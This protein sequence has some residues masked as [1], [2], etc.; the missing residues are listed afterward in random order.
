MEKNQMSK[1][2]PPG[3]LAR[4]RDG[5]WFVCD[6]P[7]HCLAG[8]FATYGGALGWILQNETKDAVKRNYMHCRAG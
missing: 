3:W 2:E 8:P 6:A 4:L 1:K 5:E 7:W